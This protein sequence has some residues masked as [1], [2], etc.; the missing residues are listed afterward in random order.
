M[1]NVIDGVYIDV[2]HT[3]EKT[4]N[5]STNLYL[6]KD[7][8]WGI[9]KKE[10]GTVILDGMIKSLVE[11]DLIDFISAPLSIMPERA[12]YV[13]F[14]H[15]ITNEYG[16]IFIPKDDATLNIHYSLYF[17]PLRL[18]LWIA[19]M[20]TD[21]LIVVFSYVIERRLISQSSLVCYVI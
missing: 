10:N 17:E 13:Q 5:F 14:L 18:K 4:L 16:A 21:L 19:M 12:P 20:M 15:R 3:L 8:I 6:R 11:N 2:L 1:T 9:P 7:R